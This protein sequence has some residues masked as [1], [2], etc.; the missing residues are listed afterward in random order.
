MSCSEPSFPIAPIISHLQRLAEESDRRDNSCT[1]PSDPDYSIDIKPLEHHYVLDDSLHKPVP[2]DQSLFVQ[3]PSSPMHSRSWLPMIPSHHQ[4]PEHQGHHHFLQTSHNTQLQHHQHMHS[5]QHHLQQHAQHLSSAHHDLGLTSHH[6]DL[7]DC[8]DDAVTVGPSDFDG[9]KTDPLDMDGDAYGIMSGST[10]PND[11]DIYSGRAIS[12]GPMLMASADESVTKDEPCYLEALFYP[13]SGAFIGYKGFPTFEQ[14]KQLV[15][16]YVET[17]SSVK[18]NK[19]LISR[20]MY[21]DIKIVLEDGTTNVRSAQF[22]FWAKKNFQLFYDSEGQKKVMHKAKPVAV[23][24]ELYN[25]LT[26]CHMQAKHGGRDKTLCQL[27]QWHSRVPKNLISQFIKICPTCNPNSVNAISHP[28]FEL[29][30][31]G[32]GKTYQSMSTTALF[33]SP[34]ATQ[35]RFKLKRNIVCCKMSPG[36]EKVIK[37]AEYAEQAA[38]IDSASSINTNY[39][40]PS[41]NLETPP[42]ARKLFR[43]QETLPLDMDLRNEKMQSSSPMASPVLKGNSDKRHSDIRAKAKSTKSVLLSPR[44]RAGRKRKVVE[45]HSSADEDVFKALT[46]A[47]AVSVNTNNTTVSTGH[48][49]SA[50]TASMST[51]SAGNIVVGS[52]VELDGTPMSAESLLCGSPTL[53]VRSLSRDTGMLVDQLDY[54]QSLSG[55]YVDAQSQQLHELLMYTGDLHHADDDPMDKLDNIEDVDNIDMDIKSSSMKRRRFSKSSGLSPIKL[56]DIDPNTTST[57]GGANSCTSAIDLKLSSSTS[58][59]SFH[60]SCQQMP[61]HE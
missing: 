40:R 13:E 38:G 57:T 44:S 30:F 15:G 19:S 34:A 52:L 4:S 37:S 49:T 10:H 6:P 33:A 58:S 28:E 11:V 47:N 14:C 16:A 35:V 41:A 55:H 27:R 26:V 8:D 23:R 2:N 50:N 54:T 61:D 51:I 45:Q 12:P 1:I 43:I 56:S 46:A 21:E 31:G 18:K 9:L 7:D 20:D 39:S 22:R 29:D 36:I 48:G 53:S 25:V 59:V 17:L 3:T 5:Q 32:D 24:E 60:R 42:A